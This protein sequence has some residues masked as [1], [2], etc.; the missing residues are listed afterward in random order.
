[1]KTMRITFSLLGL[2]AGLLFAQS[3]SYLPSNELVGELNDYAEDPDYITFTSVSDTVPNKE[4]V[5]VFFPGGLV[6]PHAYINPLSQCLES[7]SRIIIIKADAN[8]SILP[9]PNLE[10]IVETFDLDESHRIIVGGHSLGGVSAC[11]LAADEDLIAGLILMASYPASADD[12]SDFQGQVLSITASEDRIY[13]RDIFL[14]R[15]NQ[16]PAG[17]STQI[18]SELPTFVAPNESVYFDILGGNHAQFGDYGKQKGEEEEP[19]LSADAQHS[20]VAQVIQRFK[21]ASLWD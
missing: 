19:V 17:I 11:Q 15:Q 6:D 8:L 13:D 5:F 1:M 20:I 14:E 18:L 7:F 10:D 9:T 2:L 16:L 21:Q 4:N 3:C 12:L